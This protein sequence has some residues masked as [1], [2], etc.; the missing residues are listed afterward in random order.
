MFF[1]L[2]SSEAPSNRP[3]LRVTYHVDATPGPTPTPTETLTP[4]EGPSPTASSTPTASTTPTPGPAPPASTTPPPGPAPT[5]G[6]SPTPSPT[7]ASGLVRSTLHSGCLQVPAG[8]TAQEKIGEVLLVWE[9]TATSAG[10]ELYHTNNRVTGH[11]V[12]VNGHL[13]GTLPQINWGSACTGGVRAEWPVD[14]AWLVHGVNSIRVTNEGDLQDSWAAQNLRLWVAGN[15]RGSEIKTITFTSSFDGYAQTARLQVPGNYDGTARPLLVVCHGWGGTGMDALFWYA[16]EA[17]RRGW[18]LVGPE[19]RGEHTASRGVQRDVY[20]VVAYMKQGYA[21]D[22]TRVYLAGVSM[23]GMMAATTG[24][25]YPDLFAAVV[26]SKGPSK[27][28]DWYYESATW[29]QEVFYRE[30]GTAPSFNPFAYQSRSAYYLARNYRHLP[31]AITHP[32]N[33]TV[34]PV[35]HAHDLYNAVL[36]W[37]PVHVEIHTYP[38]DHDASSPDLGPRWLFDFFSRYTLGADPRDLEIR[39]DEG[40]GYY[41][42]AVE[43]TPIVS[44]TDI[45]ARYDPLLRYIHA[46]VTDT[47]R[48]T[49]KFDL[50]RMGLDVGSPYTVEDTNLTTGDLAVTTVGPV[51]GW[52]VLQTGQGSH[53]FLITQGVT[54]PPAH[55]RLRQGLEGYTGTADTYIER[56]APTQNFSSDGKLWLTTSDYRAALLR[57]DTSLIPSGKVVKAAKLTLWA[58]YWWGASN[59]DLGIYPLRRSWNVAEATWAQARSGE[60]WGAAGANSTET[61]RD[62][63][64]FARITLVKLPTPVAT[65]Y[66]VNVTSLVQEWVDHPERNYGVALKS[67]GA[68]S[69]NFHLGSSRSLESRRP[70]LEVSYADPTP[71]PTPFPTATPTATLTPGPATSPTPRPGATI[72]G[73][74]WNDAN[75][76]G[77]RD[78]GELPLAGAS[79]TLRYR[80]EGSSALIVVGTRTTGADGRYRFE[81]LMPGQYYLAVAPP[82]GYSASTSSNVSLVL[83]AGS[84]WQIDFGAYSLGS[85]TPSFPVRWAGALPLVRR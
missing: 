13:V 45:S 15:V 61:D 63:E 16:D 38:G 57:F 39:T 23:G 51:N 47:Q 72:S 28:D 74:V 75:A 19:L 70:V 54:P 81:G 35:H 85:P 60:E 73:L 29:R 42:L 10:L 44:F 80:P 9:G 11:K 59:M 46:V 5:P 8:S 48:V 58:T 31:L 7:F 37:Q 53:R 40:K 21:V 1:G 27:L 33:D 6:P 3:A 82:A 17:N 56:G 14:P 67:L 50:A 79:L 69:A 77:L 49:V 68:G 4:T 12:Y 25:K 78:P 83:D 64:A 18:L 22:P 30:V 52:L 43:K 34:V 26:D 55:L 76:D 20:D 32:E 2:S 65:P 71:V 62:A 41:W 66:I 84:L 36:S 24:A